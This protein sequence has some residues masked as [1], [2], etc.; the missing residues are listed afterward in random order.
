MIKSWCSTQAILALSSG[1]A[2]FYGIVKGASIGLGLRSMLGDFGIDVAIRIHPDAS[3]A[4][5]I[6]KHVSAEDI[7]V[8]LHKTGQSITSGRH[9]S[10]PAD[11]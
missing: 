5:G 4:K 9:S 10:A 7:R 1:E 6:T 3:A 11:N 2:E 8:H